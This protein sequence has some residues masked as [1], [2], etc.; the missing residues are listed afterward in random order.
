MENRCIQRS[1]TIN[2]SRL[3]WVRLF[4]W[5]D[6]LQAV[7][8][9][10]CKSLLSLPYAPSLIPDI[11]SC[12]A[13]SRQGCKVYAT[14]RNLKTIGDFQDPGIE[15]LCLDVTSDDAVQRVVQDIMEREGRIDVVV[16]N[17]GTMRPG[18]AYS[19][20]SIILLTSPSCFIQDH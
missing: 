16:N 18:M 19:A 5:L 7:S 2:Q 11:H 10:H 20:N 15:K 9:S 14:S 6:A 8:D 3:L 12:E 13:F 17:A 1:V 4:W